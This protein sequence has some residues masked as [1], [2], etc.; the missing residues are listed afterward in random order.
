MAT[1]LFAEVDSGKV[2]MMRLQS[3]SIKAV[4]LSWKSM[5]TAVFLA[6]DSVSTQLQGTSGTCAFAEALPKAKNPRGSMLHLFRQCSG[7]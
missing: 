7:D 6:F 2:L 3:I 5:R 1:T 4:A